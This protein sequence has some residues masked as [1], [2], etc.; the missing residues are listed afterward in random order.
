MVIYTYGH[1]YPVA[2]VSESTDRYDCYICNDSRD[3][4]FCR[5]LR[6]KE[7]EAVPPLVSWL[8]AAADP[9]V[10][11]DFLEYFIF[12]DTLCIVMKYV[13][14]LTL[15]NKL[16]TE[17]LSLRERLELFRRILERAVLLD[18]PDYFL[19]KCMD[20]KEIIV[21]PDLTVGFNYP[22]E[23]ITGER[24]SKP[25]PRIV[26]VFRRVFALEIER[27][28]PDELIVFYNWLQDYRALDL[29]ELYSQYYLMMT[30]LIERNAGTEEPKTLLYRLWE[31][32]K[33]LWQKCKRLLMFV[34]LVISIV[35]LV[36]TINTADTS[37]GH[38]PN[39]DSIGTVRIDKNR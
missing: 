3:G 4:S 18:I 20:L 2:S 5:I 35:Y 10:F 22:I 14:G 28:V 7:K 16:T 33:K 1:E 13:R 37:K 32:V 11:T 8:S 17:A 19:E 23:D 12:E 9:A 31:L 29:K 38:D 15:A 21:A 6:I 34:L 30:Q 26:E 24:R 27:R 25:L 36:F 39:F